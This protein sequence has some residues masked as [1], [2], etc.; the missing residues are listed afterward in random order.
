MPVQ[1]DLPV[2][3]TPFIPPSGIPLLVLVVLALE[4]RLVA[5]LAVD[6]CATWVAPLGHWLPLSQANVVTPAADVAQHTSDDV[7]VRAPQMG[8]ELPIG[9]LPLP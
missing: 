5:L 2:Q 4:L 3:V 7:H 6:V 1:D 8:A 9:L